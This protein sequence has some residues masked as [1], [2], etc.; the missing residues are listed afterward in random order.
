MSRGCSST[1]TK[2]RR[3][4]V[5]GPLC[6][7]GNHYRGVDSLGQVEA[8]DQSCYIPDNGH[9]VQILWVGSILY[10][11]L[12]GYEEDKITEGIV[13]I[14][15]KDQRQNLYKFV[16]KCDLPIDCNSRIVPCT[17]NLIHQNDLIPW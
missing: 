1:G 11:L 7:E 2:G 9:H 5:L 14:D 13:S 12:R 15:F 6:W 16:R 8:S 17:D 3:F 4:G 10:Q